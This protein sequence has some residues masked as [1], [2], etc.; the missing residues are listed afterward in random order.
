M[1]ISSNIFDIKGNA[2]NLFSLNELGVSENVAVHE[3]CEFDSIEL[4]LSV[5]TELEEITVI[6]SIA[7]SNWFSYN[8][9][10]ERLLSSVKFTAPTTSDTVVK[11]KYYYN[12]L[13]LPLM[14]IDVF[15]VNSGENILE[16]P[17]TVASQLMLEFVEKERVS[18]LWISKDCSIS[19]AEISVAKYPL[20]IAFSFNDELPFFR[21]EGVFSES[22]PVKLLD[23]K[24]ALNR[25]LDSAEEPLLKIS[26]K[27]NAE[28]SLHL[29][30]YSFNRIKTRFDNSFIEES[31]EN[32]ILL[33]GEGSSSLSVNIE[34]NQHLKHIEF[35]YKDEI[36]GYI[37]KTL[38]SEESSKALLCSS[39]YS[40]AQ[41]YKLGSSG[42]VGLLGVD[43]LVSLE[44]VP[45]KA[46]LSLYPDIKGKP[47]PDP[48]PESD[49]VLEINDMADSGWI[50][51]KTD[52][53]VIVETDFWIVLNLSD[54]EIH[55]SQIP[56][57]E[58]L[59]ASEEPTSSYR[60]G[61]CAWQFHE[62]SMPLISRVTVE[63]NKVDHL[64]FTLIRGDKKIELEKSIDDEKQVKLEYDRLK[65]LNVI[66]D[67]LTLKTDCNGDGNIR[68]FNTEIKYSNKS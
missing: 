36:K 39:R 23:F 37:W 25:V 29:S 60:I 43:L 11:V 2:D 41:F 30:D 66:D 67:T 26:S 48:L 8:W 56:E 65:E 12:G 50:S 13:W 64:L 9:K 19:N 47:G 33:S 55:C 10:D 45:V 4:S 62:K 31:N 21:N 40:A 20:D 15:D 51:F 59:P 1:I 22:G 27:I 49:M 68:I 5:D 7:K 53:A 6:E 38:L 18:G 34:E 44:K 54:G 28:I 63:G 46:V 52:K 17:P 24:E 61:N 42:P 3:N 58:I 35:E 16:F 32:N 57:S 14:P